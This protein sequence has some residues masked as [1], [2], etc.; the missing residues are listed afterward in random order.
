M[1]GLEAPA[2]Y[3]AEDGLVSHQFF[4]SCEGLIPQ[5]K[6]IPGTGSWSR[7]VSEQGEGARDGGLQRGNEDRG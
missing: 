4:L 3:V 7:W 5:C 2:A 1:E 6:G